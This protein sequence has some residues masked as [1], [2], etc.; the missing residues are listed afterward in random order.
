MLGANYDDDG[1]K[2]SS[3]SGQNGSIVEGKSYSF[4][5]N[6]SIN[7]Y[8]DEISSN[9][10]T[11]IFQCNTNKGRAVTYEGQNNT[12][13]VIF[14]TFVF[15]GIRTEQA[16]NELMKIYMD[17]LLGTGDQQ[18]P[19][20]SVTSPSAGEE[21]QQGATHSIEW[22]ATD[23]VGVVSRAIYFTDD[24]G[25]TWTLVDSTGSNT[26][27]FDWTVPTTTSALCMIKVFAYDAAGNVGANES[28]QFVIG[29]TGIIPNVFT[30]KP[31]GTYKVTITNVQGRVIS[32]FMTKNLDLKQIRESL[33]SG[34]HIVHIMTSRE[35]ISKKFL[36][37]R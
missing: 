13:K 32:S 1:D 27:T 11:M 19:V 15:G 29:G 17:Y 30:I 28:A 25:S 3:L 12:Y 22:T 33:P 6:L 34:L 10:G 2:I 37:V 24:D 20:V 23:N 8:M 21:L 35:R 18:A 26:G 36:L 7:T 31:A 16:K 9:G 14:S 5:Q 4:I